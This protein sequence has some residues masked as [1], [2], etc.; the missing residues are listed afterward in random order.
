MELRHIRYFLAVADALHFTKA[1]DRMHVSQPALSAQIKQLEQE[2]GV[3][4]F[5]RLGRSVQLTRAGAIFREHATNV[6]REL[7]TAQSAIAEAEGLHRGALT[8]GVLQ[9]VNAYVMPEVVTR[10]V[11]RYSHIA[12]KLEEL[13]GQDIERRV[14]DGQL[15]VGV[16]FDPPAS[17]KLE[18]QPLFEEDMVLI[19]ARRHR[20]AK[21]RHR[22]LAELRDEPLALLSTD[23]SARRLIDDS[24][25]KAQVRPNIAVE[26]NSIEGILATVRAGQLTTILPR[27]AMGSG[28]DATL[29]M[30]FLTNPTPT[31]G[32]GLLWKKGGYRSAVVLAL[33]EQVKSVMADCLGKWRRS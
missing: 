28:G 18:C 24:F 15:D 7:E 33:A 29:Q 2:V 3:P 16:G 9:T 23:F 27:L 26:S 14:C 1:A 32:V 11:A 19:T 5:D 17:D 8:I 21:H 4:L 10:F 13:S 6:L 30:V 22:T 20:L 12:I 25:R 31:R